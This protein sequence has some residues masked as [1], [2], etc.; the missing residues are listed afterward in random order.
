M[1]S[2][3]NANR[4]RSPGGPPRDT[5]R[6]P[7]DL[8][9][10]RRW[11]QVNAHEPVRLRDLAAVAGVKQRTLEAHCRDYLGTTPIGWVRN[12]R[13]ARARQALL[14]TTGKRTVTQVAYDSGF[15]QPGRFAAL[16]TRHF[17]EKPSRTL[18]RA[19]L[20]PAEEFDD[21]A[22]LLTWSALPAA[23]AVA[24]DQCNTALEKLDQAQQLAPNYG[25]PRALA[26]W[27]LSQRAAQH[28]GSTPREDLERAS[29][30]SAQALAVAP[31]D[32]MVLTLASGTLT[33]AHRLDEADLLLERALA[34]D[35]W[36]PIAWL[37]RGWVSAYQGNA[38]RAI[39]ELSSAPQLMPF[40]PL[41][42]LAYIGIGCAHFSAERYEKAARWVRAGLDANPGSFWAAR[43]LAAA[44]LRAGERAEGRRV[45]RQLLRKDPRLTV[46]I[47]HRAWPFPSDFMSC[48]AESLAEAG[49]PRG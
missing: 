29:G 12:V 31:T 42:H 39:R 40:D 26:A 25:L 45:V 20:A 41:R 35:P 5:P 2:R 23:F 34:L 18:Q 46:T 47:A 19:R 8:V 27:C 30:L 24:P 4:K 6:L 49:L 17:G 37:R 9:R 3:R 16:Y 1:S 38:E 10:V 11:L 7:G 33:L 43:V 48:L 14:D 44:A 21:R 36:S 32:A 28:F 13:L 22:L 15:T